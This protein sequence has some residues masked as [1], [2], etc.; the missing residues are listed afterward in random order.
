MDEFLPTCRC[1]TLDA[2]L[3]RTWRTH[4]VPAYRSFVLRVPLPSLI[5]IAIRCVQDRRFVCRVETFFSQTP[6]DAV[7]FSLQPAVGCADAFFHYALAAAV[8]IL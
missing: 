4:L 6:L 5:S 2:V 8:I 7:L 1:A 3:A